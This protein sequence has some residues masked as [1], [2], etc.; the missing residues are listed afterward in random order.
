MLFAPLCE[1]P[2][3][4]RNGVY[5]P[6]FIL[7]VILCVPTA[8]VDNFGGLLV[9]RFLLGFFSSPC[10]AN[11]AASVGDMVRGAG[12]R[13]LNSPAADVSSTI[14]SCCPCTCLVGRQRAFGVP[15]WVRIAEWKH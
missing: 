14:C 8:L 1:I 3:I 15:R 6:C 10:L 12:A 4:G 2:A 11:G 5:T 7:F 9:L 13:N